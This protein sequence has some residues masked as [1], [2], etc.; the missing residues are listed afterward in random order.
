L[1]PKSD[2]Y[3]A[4]GSAMKL[5]VRINLFLFLFVFIIIG[6]L[7]LFQSVFLD[8][9]YMNLKTKELYENTDLIMDNIDSESFKS[10]T[11]KISTE[12]KI[13]VF[14]YNNTTG[15]EIYTCEALEGKCDLHKIVYTRQIMGFEINSDNIKSLT[16]YARQNGSSVL[17]KVTSKGI[18]GIKLELSTELSRSDSEQ[19]VILAK[20][21]KNSEGDDLIFLFNC[22]IS[23]LVTTVNT[24]N[25]ILV[26]ISLILIV[27]ATLFSLGIAYFISK[28]ISDINNSAKELA[29]GNY[30]VNFEG[31]GFSEA[32]ELGNTLNYA[33]KEL[34]KVDRLKTELISNISHDLRTP[35]TMIAGYAEMMCDMPDEMTAEN[36]QI[37]IDESQRMKSL[38]NDVLDISKLQSGNAEF[39]M[40]RFSLTERIESEITRYNKLRCREGYFISFDYDTPVYVTGDSTRLVQVLYNL[41]NNAVAH[42]GESKLVR[43]TQSAN[44]GRVRISVTD[45]G[46]GISPEHLP[47]IW[48]RYYKV[49]KSGKRT[50]MGSGLGLSI[51]KTVIEAHKGRCGVESSLGGGSTFWFELDL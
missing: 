14:V 47:L 11:M 16:D 42:S 5:R 2:K 20:T 48:D 3:K 41:L 45:F 27:L 35:I 44:Q 26:Y 30:N 22:V 18:D 31:S 4:P 7:W 29:K 51:V 15:K 40:E 13:C 8:K 38:V 10:Q 36:L 28:P 33:S 34:S 39:K 17:L 25:T 9:I 21:L 6:I 19:S 32:V 23:P 37:I 12:H 43:V 1:K 49:D 50:S 24:L 46:E